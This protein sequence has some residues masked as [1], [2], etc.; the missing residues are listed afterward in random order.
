MNLVLR[1]AL[2]ALTRPAVHRFGSDPSQVADLHVPSGAGPHPVVVLLH[3]GHWKTGLGKLTCRPFAR[4]LARRGFAACSPGRLYAS[5]YSAAS[6]PPSSGYANSNPN[7]VSPSGR[8]RTG[9][10]NWPLA[11]RWWVKWSPGWH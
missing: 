2:S 8:T 4:D 9:V 1:V 3:G 5:S 6:A 10:A 7:S 11:R